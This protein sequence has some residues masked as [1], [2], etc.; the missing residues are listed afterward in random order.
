MER[1]LDYKKVDD[2]LK[3][4]A[5]KHVDIKDYVGDS[6]TELDDKV[7]T[8]DG[9]QS[10][11][12]SFYGYEGKLSG[13]QQRT[14]NERSLSF[15]I[16]YSGISSGD[17][18]AQRIAKRDAEI[19]GLEVLSRINVESKSP[20]IGWLYDNFVKESVQYIELEQELSEGLFGM[21]FH[22]NLKSLEP[23]VVTPDKWSDGDQFCIS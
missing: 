9:L 5:E 18:E 22:F 15:A 13:N 3:S 4:L 21:E 19:I 8:T 23:L 6:T 20:A 16:C 10:P 14:F 17:F 12:M 11:F 2:Y 7:N 1:V